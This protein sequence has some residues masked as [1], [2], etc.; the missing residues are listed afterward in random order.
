MTLFINKVLNM[1]YFPVLFLVFVPFLLFGQKMY[2]EKLDDCLLKFI[3]EDEEMII[4][5]EKND[6]LMVENFLEGL[7]DKYVERLFGGVM[8]QIMVDTIQ[9]I[10]CVSYT[11]KTTLSDR[12]FDI[13]DRIKNMKGWHRTEEVLVEENICALLSILFDKN[14]IS[15][16]RTGYNRNIGQQILSSSSFLRYEPV[17]NSEDSTNSKN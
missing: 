17:V 15:V 2:D 16:I 6:S 14:Q 10:C 1:K 8:L 5:Y 11:N 12:R 9:Q 13:P 3:L 7:E 4:N